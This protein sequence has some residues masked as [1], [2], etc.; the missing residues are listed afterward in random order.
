M[1][2]H[3]ISKE[4]WSGRWVSVKGL[5]RAEVTSVCSC[6]SAWCLSDLSLAGE[7]S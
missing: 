5:H 1:D 4:S 7:M 3:I 6:C 2:S